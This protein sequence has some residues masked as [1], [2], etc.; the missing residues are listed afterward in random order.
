MRNRW[1]PDNND[2]AMQVL[3]HQLRFAGGF[4]THMKVID[5]D[6]PPNVRLSFERLLKFLTSEP[7]IK[8]PITNI[9]RFV[10]PNMGILRSSDAVRYAVEQLF[11]ALGTSDRPIMVTAL[12]LPC[13]EVSAQFHNGDLDWINQFCTRHGVKRINITVSK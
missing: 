12:T 8:P 10:I 9:E 13:D 3:E 7:R 2:K 1:P 5:L 6:T 11:D 4:C